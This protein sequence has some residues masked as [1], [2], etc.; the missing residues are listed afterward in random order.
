MA[1][2]RLAFSCEMLLKLEPSW[3][4]QEVAGSWLGNT[5]LKRSPKA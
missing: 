1:K 4:R 3:K 2:S 5:V